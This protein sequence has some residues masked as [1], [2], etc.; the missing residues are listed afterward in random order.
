M[1]DEPQPSEPQFVEYPRPK[2]C[3]SKSPIPPGGMEYFWSWAFCAGSM[4]A[5]GFSILATLALGGIGLLFVCN[6]VSKGYKL[7]RTGRIAQVII[8]AFLVG[9]W[10]MVNGLNEESKHPNPRQTLQSW[11]GP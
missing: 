11:P 5:T 2:L 1:L 6:S 9:M 10:T 4:I 8:L 3:P 7:G